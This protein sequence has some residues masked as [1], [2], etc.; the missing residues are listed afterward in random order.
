MNQTMF[1]RRIVGDGAPTIIVA[2]VGINHG[3][4]PGQAEALV[5]AAASAGA[6]AVKFQTYHTANRVAPDSPIAE[7]LRR[8]EL[9][10]A[11]QAQLKALA[12]SLG[13][14]FFSTPFDAECVAFLDELGVPAVKI[15]SFDLVNH[16]L[17]RSVIA[18]RRL[19]IAS[20]GMATRAEVDH[21]VLMA[22]ADQVPLVLLHCVSAYPTQ[23]HEADL[24]VIAHLRALY[25]VP[26]GYSDHTLGVDVASLSVA[27]G[28]V[29]I[30]K[31]FTLDR[32]A[33]GPDHA[34]SADPLQLRALC[35]RA[36]Q[37]EAILGSGE[38]R[39]REVERPIMSYRR[40]T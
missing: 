40:R 25:D 32:S 16:E 18:T 17:V 31:H 1:G 2:E 38:L 33:D 3:G 34:L 22:R 14:E 6:D 12:D 7:V 23:P 19:V 10:F 30:E 5:R 28:A 24:A 8:C 9:S 36:R 39:C 15:A 27:A 26:V 20:T 35:D 4:D 13:I 21:V 29:M 11:Q 37:I